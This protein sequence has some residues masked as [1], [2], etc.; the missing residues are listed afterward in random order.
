[1]ETKNIFIDTSVYE[2]N[3]FLA[4]K[5]MQAL[6]KYAEENVIKIYTSDILVSELKDRVR[7]KIN[8][9]KREWKKYRNANPD[10]I[11]KNSELH[12]LF[13]Q[14]W[15]IDFKEQIRIIQN[16]ID[17]VVEETPINIIKT[18]NTNVDLIFHRY[19][20]NEP[21]FKEG[22]KKYEFPDA[23]ILQSIIDW[24]TQQKQKMIVLSFDKD[25]QKS[26][27]DNLIN[28]NDIDKLLEHILLRKEILEKEQ[29]V[30]FVIT[31]VKSSEEKLINEVRTWLM[32]DAWIDSGEADLGEVHIDQIIMT[33]PDVT[34][35]EENDACVD[36]N[37]TV[38][39][40]AEIS[41][42]DYANGFYDKE[43]KRWYFVESV[44][45]TLYKEIDIVTTVNVEYDLPKKTYDVEI[46]QI[47]NDESIDLGFDE[48]EEMFI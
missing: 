35:L 15:S 1:M 44:N 26:V 41:Y 31:A 17:K 42:D 21:P 29:K 28:Y 22:L 30:D 45:D 43:D 32:N 47:N 24:C 20:N 9:S 13:G 3:N 27:S 23:F 10:G 34:L 38:D 2:A 48:H 14:L 46:E 7:K 4:G 11:F 39:M 8:E 25:W 37:F 5:K 40:R 16:K 36:V 19:F 6:I 33:K 18:T 12:S